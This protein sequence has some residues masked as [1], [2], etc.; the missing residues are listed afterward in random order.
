[1]QT[2]MPIFS[3]PCC[4]Q[5][6]E[7]DNESLRDYAKNQRAKSFTDRPG[8][9]QSPWLD[10]SAE[11]IQPLVTA[12]Q[13]H[14]DHVAK[15]VYELRDGAN[16]KLVNGWININDPGLEQ[17]NNNFYHLHTSCFVSVVYYVDCPDD[18]GDLV[19]IPPHQMVDYALPHQLIGTFNIFNSQRWHI[20]P[21]QGKLASF[22]AWINHFAQP[23]RGN[24]ERISIAFNGILDV[25]S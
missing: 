2:M 13:A 23:N 9:W 20:K 17:L 5:M 21:K 11:P 6:L 12:V 7:I 24:R 8:G 16:I 14:M 3:T 19:L 25:K 1:M 15:E 10:L 18:C 22:P 4:E